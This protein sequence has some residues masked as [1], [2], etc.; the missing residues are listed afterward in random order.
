V[1]SDEK[2]MLT[3]DGFASGFVL[4]YASTYVIDFQSYSINV[5]LYVGSDEEVIIRRTPSSTL[6]H[7]ET[8]TKNPTK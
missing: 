7:T 8:R 4:G 6:G 2:R 5:I 3:V 1:G